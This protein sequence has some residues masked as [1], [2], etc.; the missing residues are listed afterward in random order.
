MTQ[1]S[2]QAKAF[3]SDL[4]AREDWAMRFYGALFEH[5]RECP[6]TRCRRARACRGDA[7]PCFRKWWRGLSEEERDVG[8]GTIRA[9]IGTGA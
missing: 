7:A 5:W 2:K 1:N 3:T 9:A 6:S 4:R 8:R